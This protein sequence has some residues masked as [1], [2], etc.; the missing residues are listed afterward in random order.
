MFTTPSREKQPGVRPT[1]PLPP[2]SDER[3]QHLGDLEQL[4]PRCLL[5]RR[6]A[7]R[8][9]TVGRVER[10]PAKRVHVAGTEPTEAPGDASHGL[11]LEHGHSMV[12]FR[13]LPAE[14]AHELGIGEHGA[15]AL[16]CVDVRYLDASDRVLLQDLVLPQ[17]AEDQI[18]DPANV[19]ERPSTLSLGLG[20]I[21]H[22]SDVSAAHGGHD[23]LSDVGSDVLLEA[24]RI[25]DDISNL[26]LPFFEDAI[27][28]FRD[29]LVSSGAYR[30]LLGSG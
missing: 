11:P 24:D 26:A 18:H 14:V 22:V 7:K 5:P 21:E 23:H 12:L 27:R 16:V 17:R 30:Q 10:L 6:P 2:V 4:G 20:L 13:M 19:R 28:G 8:E 9:S 3:P 29:G 15:L 1:C 25:V